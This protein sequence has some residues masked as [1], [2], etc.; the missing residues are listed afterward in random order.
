MK[1]KFF[2]FVFSAV[3]LLSLAAQDAR[4]LAGAA[5]QENSPGAPG[6]EKPLFRQT[7]KT[8]SNACYVYREYVVMTVGSEDVGEEIRI[9]KRDRA[10]DFRKNC[11]NDKRQP[12]LTI[13][14]DDANY[15]FGLTGDK[16]L[17]D[18]GTSA[19][20]RGL[21]I[22]SLTSKKVIYSTVYNESVRVGGNFVIYNK[23]SR[24][25]GALKNC[26][27]S[28]K[29]KKQGG[30]IGWVRPTRLD[31]TTLKETPAGQLTCVYVE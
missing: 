31:L 26:P 1:I 7:N 24:V 11:A 23:P 29:W 28:R 25:G 12:Y 14:N 17:I 30:G 4:S 19:G 15:F 10:A 8:T 20:D 21:D 18:S 3:L 6:T 27:N 2:G 22:V 13:E 9:F 5:R 16:F